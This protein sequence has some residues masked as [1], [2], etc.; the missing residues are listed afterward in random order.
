MRSVVIVGVAA[1]AFASSASEAEARFRMRLGSSSYVS[2][3][4]IGRSS[5]VVVPGIGLGA[6]GLRTNAYGYGGDRGASQSIPPIRSVLTADALP[7]LA[8]DAKP[9][10]A[11]PA[12]TAPPVVK[13]AQP[14][15]RSGRVAG[16]G[17]GFCLMN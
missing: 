2:R 9:D 15:C 17:P 16:S 3:P 5:L 7:R 13:V 1:L 11:A 14:W 4:P 12:N 8:E 10:A 6:S